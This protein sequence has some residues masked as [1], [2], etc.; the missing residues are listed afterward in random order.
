M[1]APDKKKA[2]TPGKPLRSDEG[3]K[4]GSCQGQAGG[5]VVHFLPDNQQ[6]QKTFN[7]NVKT[8]L[9]LSS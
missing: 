7:F 6:V 4:V 9:A 1:P 8:Q 3:S 2:E 5:K